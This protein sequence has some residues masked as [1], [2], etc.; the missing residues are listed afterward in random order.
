M[1]N[2][3]ALINDQ[4]KCVNVGIRQSP[5]NINTE[6]VVP[7]SSTKIEFHCKDVYSG[8]ILQEG[9]ELMTAHNGWTATYT[10][11][12]EESTW[13]SVQ[14]HF[15]SPS[16]HSVDGHFYDAE[17]HTVF[18]NDRNKKQLLVLGILFTLDEHAEENEF[19]T[20]LEL[21]DIYEEGEKFIKNVP[22]EEFI[23]ST[24]NDNL[25][26]YQGSLTTPTCDEVVEWFV[27]KHPVKINEEQLHNFEILWS[28]NYEFAM[29][30]GNNRYFL[31]KKILFYSSFHIIQV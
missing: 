11:A 15:H 24:V 9:N 19:L 8:I 12:T 10:S 2:C 13:T 25:F 4:I 28:K 5:M 31:R 29:G 30:N 7:R 23:S 3:S 14:F 1:L 26:N 6:T 21:E 22:M 20:A 18:R 27:F 17:M 16:E